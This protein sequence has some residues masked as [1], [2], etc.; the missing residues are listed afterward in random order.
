MKP[1]SRTKRTPSNGLVVVALL[2]IV[3]SFIA[4]YCVDSDESAMVS[5]A[6]AQG[7]D[8]PP[9]P[10]GLSQEEL[11][12]GVGA[13]GCYRATTGDGGGRCRRRGAFG[14]RACRCESGDLALVRGVCCWPGQ[15]VAIGNRCVGQPTRCPAGLEATNAGCVT[16]SATPPRPPPP[17]PPPGPSSTL[18]ED[19]ST[20][21]LTFFRDGG[22]LIVGGRAGGSLDLR[23][24]RGLPAGCTGFVSSSAPFSVTLPEMV[25][26]LRIRADAA[27]GDPTLVVRSESGVYTCNDD[28]N[29]LNPQVDLS[30]AMGTYLIWVGSYGAG[31][32][33]AIELGMTEPST[34]T[35]AFAFVGTTVQRRGDAG[36]MFDVGTLGEEGCVGFVRDS[37]LHEITL[38]HDVEA[39][40]I[41][42]ESTADTTLIVRDNEGRMRCAD[43]VLGTNP[44]VDGAFYAGVYN[45][46]V[47]TKSAGRTAPYELTVAPRPE[48]YPQACGDNPSHGA[49]VVGAMVRL[50]RHRAVN[51]ADN[52][53]PRMDA[54]VGRVAR[55]TLVVGPDASNCAMVRVD[56]DSG[57]FAW[58]VRDLTPILGPQGF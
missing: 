49:A 47:G 57:A 15:G 8:C 29:D 7:R 24:V 10:P 58:R 26:L 30:G 56:A 11:A 38:S 3:V 18:R 51:G 50:N 22:P 16:P 32:G 23:S 43:N 21:A 41:R 34:S 52:W 20:R 4:G 19:S 31:S 48:S 17:P 1:K 45:V 25:P 55:I 35:D 54:Y 14:E 53:A 9:T 12:R 44:M 40:E 39:L 28:T 37:A 27:S 5:I 33:T 42:V 13:D 46:W 2:A 36:G 6:R